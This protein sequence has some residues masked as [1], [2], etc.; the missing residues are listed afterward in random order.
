M[1]QDYQLEVTDGP[2]IVQ[3]VRSH[4]ELPFLGAEGA[5]G[6]EETLELRYILRD[7]SGGIPK[8]Y[9]TI[10]HPGTAPVFSRKPRPG[11]EAV[12]SASLADAPKETLVKFGQK[13]TYV[14]ALRTEKGSNR[15]RVLETHH[16]TV[17]VIA[18]LSGLAL[19]WTFDELHEGRV[20]D[21]SG[22]QDD[23]LGSQQG[24]VSGQV[25]QGRAGPEKYARFTDGEPGGQIDYDWPANHPGYPRYTVAFWAWAD[26]VLSAPSKQVKATNML[27]MLNQL[28]WRYTT[29]H[30]FARYITPAAAGF[31]DSGPSKL[32]PTQWSHY[33]FRYD[34]D[35]IDII[36]NGV[37]LKRLNH[38]DQG[39]AL[40]SLILG[41]KDR[42][43]DGEY[44]GDPFAGGIDD[45]RIYRRALTIEE[46]RMLQALSYLATHRTVR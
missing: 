23:T 7:R 25:H 11:Q 19:H 29:H 35:T 17:E 43:R 33:V 28:Q 42:Y 14:L 30:D 45:V 44:I 20:Q 27:H 8:T 34:G 1:S 39:M 32:V 6:A 3:P 38:S 4:Y 9:M 41:S 16:I 46:I 26:G 5:E 10:E 2:N 40:T 31:P 21:H 37:L 18:P 13:G 24:K 12:W 36:V 15:D 22:M